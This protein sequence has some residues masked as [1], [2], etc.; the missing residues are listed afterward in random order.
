[1]FSFAGSRLL[2]SSLQS[3]VMVIAL[4]V[5]NGSVV[6]QK[7]TANSERPE[8]P[9]DNGIKLGPTKKYRWQVGV[10]ITARAAKTAAVFTTIP[11]P[12]Q[13]AEQSV[14]LVT[15]DFSP[16]VRGGDFR[17]I[18]GR[19]KQFT[20]NIRSLRPGEKA[21]AM[22]TFDV[23]VHS[24]MAPE[25]TSIFKI[26]KRVPR[27]VKI[28]LNASEGI[29]HR[30][31]KL[32]KKVDEIIG[33][34]E[35][36]WEQVQSLYDWVRENILLNREQP[37]GALA[38]FRSGEGCS[39][40]AVSLF[41]AMCRVHKVPA[42]FVWVEGHQYAEFYLEDDEGVGHWFPAQIVGNRDFGSM[43][44]PVIILQR[45]DNIKVPEKENRQKYV[46]E[47]LMGKAR[48]ARPK[49]QFHRKL[50]PSQ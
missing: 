49:V 24:V 37:E 8:L 47:F 39:E 2:V 42:R 44:D 13:W 4:V 50:L 35:N 16:T 10:T 33:Q 45:G 34:E 17:E 11:V 36:A 29:N 46:A 31:S 27:D 15:E 22:M 48:G 19:V 18:D 5:T 38:A 26:P 7:S 20:A 23:E 1:M 21:E 25:D 12:N 30:N 14:R 3:T 6:A 40:D 28:S 43:S 32:R 41:I 9:N